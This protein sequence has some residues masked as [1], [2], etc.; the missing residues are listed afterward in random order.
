MA[1]DVTVTKRSTHL[2]TSGCACRTWRCVVCGTPDGPDRE[3]RWQAGDKDPSS[4]EMCAVCGAP[5]CDG[6]VLAN[7]HDCGQDTR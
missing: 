2:C 1:T 7:L 5:L 4:W 3:T 6:C